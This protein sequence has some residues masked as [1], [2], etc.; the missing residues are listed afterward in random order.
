LDWSQDFFKD[1]LDSISDGVY[2]LD[3]ERRIV[4]WNRGAERLTGYSSE[5]VLGK[6]CA[7]DILRHVGCDGKGLCQSS[8]CPAAHVIR[9]G[10]PRER[11]VFFHHKQGHRVP[12][13]ARVAPMRDQQGAVIGAVEVFADNSRAI[14]MQNQLESLRTAAL[15]DPVTVV[16]TRR[17]GELGLATKLEEMAHGGRRFGVLLV[18]LDS[19]KE[20]NDTFGHPLGDRV[21][22][23]VAGTLLNN[24][25]SYDLVSRWGG[26]EF[27]VLLSNLSEGQL[28]RRTRSL[29]ALVEA[30]SL[31][32]GGSR[33]E[34]AVSGGAT[35]AEPGDTPDRV[36]ERA[37]RALYTSKHRGGSQCTAA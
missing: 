19:F 26:D 16:A 28:M 15:L 36:I 12:V 31:H 37:D 33:I 5:E 14:E 9:E 35:V 25:R 18:D 34:V 32:E 20:I 1:V 21:L 13:I 24:V 22:S 4:F 7:D 27:L 10:E 2:C 6:S 30:S 17:Y 29:C 23:M 8:L 11:Q 3:S